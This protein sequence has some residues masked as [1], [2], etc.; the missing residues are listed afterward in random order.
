MNLTGGAAVA[1]L[2]DLFLDVAIDRLTERTP[3]GLDTAEMTALDHVAFDGLGPALSHAPRGEA[4]S[5][6]REA[7]HADLDLKLPGTY[8]NRWH[9][10]TFNWRARKLLY[11]AVLNCAKPV[12]R[13]EKARFLSGLSLNPPGNSRSSR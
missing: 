1:L 2:R 9:D 6:G 7:A 8:A 13:R 11:A 3:S 12:V 5:A 10:V 4:R